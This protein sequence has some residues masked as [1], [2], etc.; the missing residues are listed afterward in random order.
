MLPDN[1]ENQNF[2]LKTTN[3]KNKS[4]EINT[5]YCHW[6]FTI[7]LRKKLLESLIKTE[8]ITVTEGIQ[9]LLG[10]EVIKGHQERLSEFV[11]RFRETQN[12]DREE[13]VKFDSVLLNSY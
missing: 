11:D 4:D 2:E 10:E 7:L 8:E 5:L 13:P 6:P 9:A 12:Q 3:I 1:F